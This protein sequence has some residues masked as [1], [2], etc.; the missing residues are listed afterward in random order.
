MTKELERDDPLPEQFI[1]RAVEAWA[2]RELPVD[3]LADAM[4]AHSVN[5][6]AAKEGRAE[7]VRV[8]RELADSIE[9][10]P[11]AN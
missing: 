6:L 8:L 11:T 1:E 5:L 9:R 2:Q 3:I 7:A 10:K 4:L